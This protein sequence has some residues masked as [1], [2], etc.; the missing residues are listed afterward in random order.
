MLLYVFLMLLFGSFFSVYLF[1][2][3]IIFQITDGFL[4]NKGRERIWV[5]RVNVGG[6]GGESDQT[7]L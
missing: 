4:N 1:V 5:W 6:C 2:C 7:I 3:F